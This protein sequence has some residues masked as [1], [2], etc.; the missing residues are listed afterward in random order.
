M[1]NNLSIPLKK[2]IK[3][4]R[5]G[6]KAGERTEKNYKKSRKQLKKGQ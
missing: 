2:A 5:K 3:L 1:R 4:Q 6:A